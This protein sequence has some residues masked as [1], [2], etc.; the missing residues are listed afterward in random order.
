MPLHSGVR[1]RAPSTRL[2]CDPF[3]AVALRGE[4]CPLSPS[5][6]VAVSAVRARAAASLGARRPTAQSLGT[7]CLD[8][9]R[10][11]ASAS[12]RAVFTVRVSAHAEREPFSTRVFVAPLRSG[13]GGTKEA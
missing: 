11:N 8:L 10:L 6:R 5:L 3:G 13:A 1:V 7:C 12:C 2:R 4:A 9:H